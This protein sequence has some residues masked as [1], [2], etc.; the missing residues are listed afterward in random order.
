[1]LGL[2]TIMLGWGMPD[3]NAHAPNEFLRI[4]NINKGARVYAELL[5]RLADGPIGG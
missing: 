4:E 3:E 2:K 1:V 5:T